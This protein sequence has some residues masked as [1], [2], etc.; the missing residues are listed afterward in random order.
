MLV[1]IQN[2]PGVPN[3]TLVGLLMLAGAFLLFGYAFQSHRGQIVLA[4]S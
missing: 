3:L 2:A 4:G 1:S